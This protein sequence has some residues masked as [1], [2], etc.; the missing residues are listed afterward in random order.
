MEDSMS[1]YKFPLFPF[2][3]PLLLSSC[4]STDERIENTNFVSIKSTDTPRHKRVIDLY[5]SQ[6]AFPEGTIPPDLSDVVSSSIKLQGR[7]TNKK[8]NVCYIEKYPQQPK[9]IHFGFA[10]LEVTDNTIKGVFSLYRDGSEIIELNIDSDNDVNGAISSTIGSAFFT[11]DGKRVSQEIE[12]VGKI[13]GNRPI[14]RC[15]QR[16]RKGK[17]IREKWLSTIDLSPSLVPIPR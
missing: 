13:K 12:F 2:L 17:K 3:L 7:Y 8:P 14:N 4:A 6:E 5:F 10:T 11:D 1:I 15:F 9:S 16:I